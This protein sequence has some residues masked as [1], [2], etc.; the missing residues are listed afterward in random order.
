MFEILYLFL[1]ITLGMHTNRF[2][3]TAINTGS[4]VPYANSLELLNSGLLSHMYEQNLAQS[5]NQSSLCEEEA[6]RRVE[7]VLPRFVEALET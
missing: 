4:I 3:A 7:E 6:R 2:L 1:T 5:I